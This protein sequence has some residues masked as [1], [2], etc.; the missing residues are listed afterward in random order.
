ML[1]ACVFYECCSQPTM[2]AKAY[3][4]YITAQHTCTHRLKPQK[5]RLSLQ[6]GHKILAMCTDDHCTFSRLTLNRRTLRKPAIATMLALTAPAVR[7]ACPGAGCRDSPKSS[8]CTRSPVALS[9]TCTPSLHTASKKR[10]AWARARGGEGKV[11]AL[12]TGMPRASVTTPTSFC[13]AMIG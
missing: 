7:T 1:H 9:N 8:C 12:P 11:R 10:P 4:A 3:N 6:Q 13:G 5:H 2:H